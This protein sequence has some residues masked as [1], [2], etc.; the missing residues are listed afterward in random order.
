MNELRYPIGQFEHDGA[1][2][3]DDLAGWIDEIAAL[4]AA[5]RTA[6][7]GLSDAQLDTPYRPEGWTIRQVVHHVP[8]SHMNSYI[9]FKW[10]LTEDEPAIKAYYED[11]WGE[12][13]DGKTAP[14]EP[15]LQ[16]LDAV[17]ARW[18]VLLR[19]MTPEQFQR[20][21]IHPESGKS[22]LDRALGMYVWHGK[23]HVAHITSL[24]ERE[25]W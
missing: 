8:E 7:S 11:R 3:R 16:L 20:S 25:G 23:H 24:R 13:A 19:S 12:L 21:F 10:T 14:T 5:M 2:T 1:I 9:R 17:H 4:P 6:V 22:Q 18:V 15:S